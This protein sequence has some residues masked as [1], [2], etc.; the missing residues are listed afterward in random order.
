M[1][2]QKAAALTGGNLDLALA[3]PTRRLGP[4]FR[5]HPTDEELV[6]YYLRRKVRGKPFHVE[7]IAVVDIYKHEPW[8]LHAFSAV[9]STDQEWYFLVD[10]EKKYKGSRLINR[11]FTEKGYWKTSEKDQTVSHKREIVGMKKT[12]VYHA[13]KPPNGR[14]T[15]WVMHEYRLVEAELD[16]TGVQQD[17]SFILCKVFCKNEMGPP[18][19]GVY[20]P[21]NEEEWENDEVMRQAGFTSNTK[22]RL[23]FD[24]F[25]GNKCVSSDEAS[26][27]SS[28]VP[29]PGLLNFSLSAQPNLG[30]HSHLPPPPKVVGAFNSSCLE[31][32]VPPGYLK[33]INDLEEERN[34]LM[35]SMKNSEATIRRLLESNEQLEEENRRLKNLH[36]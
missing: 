11:S 5:F 35:D 3:P 8:E 7:A 34:K 17:D 30:N 13:G 22:N 10:L 15:N 4:G 28:D 16:K 36:F 6:V 27:L 32:S 21:F 26:S 9:N 1:E 29:Q 18:C 31:K 19:S 23:K 2:K 20:G 25:P 24:L 14:R 12:L 33:F